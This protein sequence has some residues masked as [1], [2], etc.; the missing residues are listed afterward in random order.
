MG[1]RTRVAA[2]AAPRQRRARPRLRRAPRSVRVLVASSDSPAPIRRGE[3][4]R[5][6]PDVRPR[7][8]RW[9]ALSALIH[10]AG[11]AA[12]LTWLERQGSVSIEPIP[13]AW[14]R[15]EP[16]AQ[17]AASAP[18]GMAAPAP[19]PAAAVPQPA[20]AAPM[21]RAP[22]RAT[23]PRPPPPPR[24]EPPVPATAPAVPIP[25][26]PVAS[27]R[28][29]VEP[30]AAPAEPAAVASDPETSGAPGIGGGGGADEAATGRE[31][32]HAVGGGRAGSGFAT[33]WM[34]HG[35]TQRPPVYPESARRRGIEGTAQVALRVAASGRVADVRLHRTS[36]DAD[37]DGAALASVRRWRFDPPPPGAEWRHAWFLV[38]IEFR[39]R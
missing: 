20:R 1:P 39:L 15:V 17:A 5:V 24:A 23:R 19:P 36:G 13:I 37:L 10:A 22:K 8:A 9:L 11:F 21:P 28:D 3:P 26:E 34:P 33:G 31:V 27:P 25:A 4:P 35:G 12:A 7:L 14:V 29:L 30:P 18:P 32:R 16:R 6:P 38:P 2:G